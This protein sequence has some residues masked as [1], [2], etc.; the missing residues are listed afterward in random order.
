MM[1]NNKWKDYLLK[2]SLPLEFEARKILEKLGFW[3]RSEHSYLR[4]NENSI[5]TEFSYD[6]DAET[7]IKE[8]CFQFLIEC[9]YR[10]DSTNWLFLPEEYNHSTRGI[11][12]TDFLNTNDFLYIKKYNDFL[13]KILN[14][15]KVS[16][17]CS[18]G[19][20]VNSNG[21]NPKSIEQ[22]IAQ[23]SYAICDKVISAMN[24]QLDALAEIELSPKGEIESNL[25]IY[26][27]IPIILTTANLFR[28]KKNA[29]IE[30]IKNAD[31]ISKIADQHEILLVE[32]NT[33]LDLKNYNYKKLSEFEKK[34]TTDLLNN[35]LK[36]KE[37]SK[38]FNFESYKEEIS[39]FP[40]GIIVIKHSKNGTG[41]QKL[42]KALHEIIAPSKKTKNIL[43]KLSFEIDKLTES[44]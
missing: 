20:E 6:I 1:Q 4:E 22:A 12:T 43:Q 9:K 33:S 32:P 3:T 13:F 26:H 15:I 41:F 25:F 42:L 17:L 14:V 7:K 11:G 34:H 31:E 36:K 21:Q 35:L 23:L 16:P 28:L 37:G 27:H 18:K 8:H 10:D 44:E 30:T 24:D 2:S 39:N 5:L 40:K 38:T 29:T 19:I